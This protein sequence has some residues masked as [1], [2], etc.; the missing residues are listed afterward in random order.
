MF[1]GIVEAVGRVAEIAP[2]GDL[3]RIAVD[4]PS[5]ADGVRIGDSV[6]VNGVCLTVVEN[7]G[8]ALAFDAA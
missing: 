4:A 5:I 7:D 3:V 2:A 6:A 8:A 1:T